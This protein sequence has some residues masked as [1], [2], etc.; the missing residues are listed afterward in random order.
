[1]RISGLVAIAIG[2]AACT[3]SEGGATTGGDPADVGAGD[4]ESRDAIADD[5]A[6]A[7]DS[8]PDDAR[9]DDT[10]TPASDAADADADASADGADGGAD[11]AADAP[12]PDYVEPATDNGDP[13]L[14]GA[15]ASTGITV[16]ASGVAT[17]AGTIASG[18]G[19][20]SFAD[21]DGYAFTVTTETTVQAELL[22]ATSGGVWSV[23]IHR[24]DKRIAAWWG[25]STEGRA[26]TQPVK[27]PAGAYFVHVSAAPP[28]PAAPVPYQLRLVSGT[29]GDCASGA[30]TT[31]AEAETSVRQNDAVS[32]D[33][34]AYP[35]LA[36]TPA[37]DAAEPTGVTLAAGASAVIEGSSGATGAGGDSYLDRDAY[38]F[39]AGPDTREV[40]VLLEHT[41]TDANLDVFVF[42]AD[43]KRLVGTGVEVGG[44]PER[45]AIA[46]EPGKTYWLWIGTRDETAIG[47]DKALPVRYRA[48]L[49]G[50]G[51]AK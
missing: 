9:A 21:A 6:G 12:P 23:S 41:A 7:S 38:V 49:C 50:R 36:A 11:G 16:G 3:R 37:A 26:L 1:M 20:A 34:Y 33:W 46:V 28:A 15:P 42:A 44:S 31:Y 25:M 14:G 18:G 4:A 8:A 17:I 30:A 32:V 10:G 13:L 29:L 2:L 51:G 24:A 19:N 47:G 43:A 35:R 27:L 45:A 40:R 5:D 22:F 48:T 39:T